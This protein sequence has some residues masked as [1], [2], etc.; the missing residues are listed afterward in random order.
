MTRTVISLP[1]D[2][3]RWLDE[4]AATAGVPMTALIREAVKLLR[5]GLPARDRPAGSPLGHTNDFDPDRDDF[6]LIPYEL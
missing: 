3:K 6:V 1:E 2:D 5:H 4:Q